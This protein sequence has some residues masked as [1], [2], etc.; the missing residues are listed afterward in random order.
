MVSLCYLSSFLG[1]KDRHPP[2]KTARAGKSRDRHKH[3]AAC[4]PSTA[5]SGNSALSFRIGA[6]ED[7]PLSSSAMQSPRGDLSGTMQCYRLMSS[8][9][10]TS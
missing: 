6:L 8:F 4:M 5:S 1:D 3:G 2:H 9:S 10:S 7:L